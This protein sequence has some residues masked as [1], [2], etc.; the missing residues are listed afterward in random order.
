MTV[1]QQAN[2]GSLYW[3]GCL[4]LTTGGKLSFYH[5]VG[6]RS[7]YFWNAGDHLRYFLVVPYPV[8]KVII[9]L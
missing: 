1:S 3:L 6:I 9:K 2:K 5:T 8:V 4:I 7:G